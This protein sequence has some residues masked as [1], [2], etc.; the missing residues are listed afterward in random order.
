MYG[1]KVINNKN[2][3]VPKSRRWP[4]EE[5][6]LANG[7]VGIVVGQMRNRRFDYTP[8]CLEIEFSTQRGYVVKFWPSSFDEERGASLELAYALTVHKA[9]GSEFGTVLL[10]LPKSGSMISRELIYTAL[11]RQKDKIVLLMQGS[12]SDLQRLSSDSYSDTSR[13]LTN[14]FKDPSPV[15]VGDRF[16]EGNL[17]HRTAR[18]EAVRSKSEVIIADL[19]Y[20]NGINYLYEEPLERNGI[21]K[22]PDFTIEDDNTGETYYWE[23]LGML[24]NPIYQR[25]WNEK[26]AW[27]RSQ[28]VTPREEGGGPNGT[29][30]VT[31]D[32][33]DGG[34]DAKAVAELI[35]E[36]FGV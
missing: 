29:L 23:H 10:V 17:I 12:P 36:L 4:S 34:F 32:S 2:Q 6:Y 11:T 24:G 28:G 22:Y 15:E 18:G 5:G 31:K 21:I 19:L 16:L 14:L 35:Q 20:A 27:L 13:R 1:D 25:R 3:H 33:A 8:R 9:Q 30:I 26:L 7:E